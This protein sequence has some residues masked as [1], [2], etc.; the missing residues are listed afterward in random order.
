MRPLRPHS[1]ALPTGLDPE[2][3]DVL[4]FGFEAPRP[5]GGY[6]PDH[7]DFA[8]F[9]LTDHDMDRIWRTNRE[10]LIE[11]AKRRGLERPWAMEYYELERPQWL[12]PIPETD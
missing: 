8:I 10:W 5:P 12:G 1:D 11:E 3:V 9:E 6:G 2:V 7:D 4:I